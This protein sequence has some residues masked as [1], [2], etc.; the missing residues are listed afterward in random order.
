MG[1]RSLVIW[2]DHWLSRRNR[3]FIFNDDPRCIVRLQLRPAPHSILLGD[4][5]IQQGDPI[6]AHHLWNER[7]PQLPPTG[8]D[9]AWAAKTL[10]LYR[11]S[12]KLVGR[13]IRQ[14]E[15][16]KDVRAIFGITAIFPPPEHGEFHPMQ[17]L[18]FCV[19]PCHSPLGA[20][21]DFWENFYSW[22]VMWAY[23]PPSVYHKLFWRLRRSEMWVEKEAFMRLY[24]G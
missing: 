19:F 8:A 4:Q 20:F 13:E 9:L 24:P 5:R 18:G 14:N 3:I 6:L 16:L 11:Y 2:F 21:G 17:R 23:N 1:V 12:L 10:S 22:V 15:A 7:I